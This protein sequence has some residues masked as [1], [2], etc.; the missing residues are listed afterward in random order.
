MSGSKFY[1]AKR[2]FVMVDGKAGKGDKYRP[3]DKK[4]WDTNWEETFGSKK[5]GNSKKNIMQP[6]GIY[7]MTDI[8]QPEDIEGDDNE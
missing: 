8:P 1:P 3:V 7:D 4:K 6:G 2:Q 5:K